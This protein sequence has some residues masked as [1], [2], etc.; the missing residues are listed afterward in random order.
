MDATRHLV[1]KDRIIQGLEE[2]LTDT[3]AVK[4]D[5]AKHISIEQHES[6]MQQL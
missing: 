1:E 5:V 2:K 4:F 6:E 3:E